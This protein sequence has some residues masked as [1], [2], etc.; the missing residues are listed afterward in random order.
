MY[1]NFIL[2]II[3]LIVLIYLIYIQLQTNKQTNKN[4]KFVN[5][6]P[7]NLG[8]GENYNISDYVND[9][10]KL[11]V[12]NDISECNNI[13]DDNKMVKKLGYSNCH[14]AKIDYIKNG[15]DIDYIYDSKINKSLSE[16]C[17]ITL[18]SGNI[19]TCYN[20]LLDKTS[21]TSKILDNLGIQV[22]NILNDRLVEREKSIVDLDILLG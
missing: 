5:I 22:S 8:I 13:K 20:K 19:L 6:E 15:L 2:L 18:N 17:P 11:D 12:I 16:I 21:S 10:N 1:L 3:I 9:I 7:T 4:N 14:D